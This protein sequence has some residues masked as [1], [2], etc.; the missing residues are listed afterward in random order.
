MRKANPLGWKTKEPQEFLALSP[1]ATCHSSD[2]MASTVSDPTGHRSNVILT[3]L[4]GQ[5]HL[6]SQL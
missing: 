6:S 1:E 2:S 5:T 4:R 3:F